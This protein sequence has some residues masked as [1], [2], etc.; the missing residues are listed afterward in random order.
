MVGLDLI[1]RLAEN[2]RP[3]ALTDGGCG[4]GRTI[5]LVKDPPL[6]ELF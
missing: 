1:D 4:G 2:G 5:D 6:G 3:F